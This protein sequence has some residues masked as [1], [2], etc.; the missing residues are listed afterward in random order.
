LPLANH[1]SGIYRHVTQ[2]CEVIKL[3]YTLGMNGELHDTTTTAPVCTVIAGPNGSGKTTFALT[4][5]RSA[6]HSRNFVNADLIAA[7]LS[8]LSPDR[9]AIEAG[10]LFLRDRTPQPL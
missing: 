4:Y 2:L 10:R 3:G 9:E 5:L 1:L 8:P 7:G 6:G